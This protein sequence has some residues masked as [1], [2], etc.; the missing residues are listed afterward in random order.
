[1]QYYIDQHKII[2]FNIIVLQ[3]H[4]QWKTK[5]AIFIFVFGTN[6]PHDMIFLT[7]RI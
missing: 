5:S 3:K 4:F 2:T 7:I 6:F 1:M